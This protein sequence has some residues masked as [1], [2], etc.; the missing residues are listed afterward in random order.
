MKS[1]SIFL[2]S[3]LTALTIY[4]QSSVMITVQG[5]STRQVVLDG[6]KYT[7]SNETNNQ[8]NL[9]SVTITGLQ[10][11]QHNLKVIRQDAFENVNN[12]ITTFNL[13]SDY[14]MQITVNTNSSVQLR[15]VQ[16]R[17]VNSNRFKIPMPDASFN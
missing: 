11:G 16:R 7:I 3:C 4:A 17:T 10:S 9:A 2:V 1:I 5:N 6:R 12:N 8:K 14:D 13:R 15:E